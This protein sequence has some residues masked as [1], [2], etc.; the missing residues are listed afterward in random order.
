[1]R[2]FARLTAISMLAALVTTV[3]AQPAQAQSRSFTPTTSQRYIE[4]TTITSEKRDWRFELQVKNAS[5]IYDIHFYIDTG[6]DEGQHPGPEFSVRSHKSTISVRKYPSQDLSEA[7]GADCGGKTRG[8]L[9]GDDAPGLF[10][11]IPQKCLTYFL[12]DGSRV[13]RLRVNVVVDGAQPVGEGAE[14][15][16]SYSPNVSHFGPWVKNVT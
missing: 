12:G 1:M 16:T 9:T 5:E 3:G 8:S 7:H 15:V 4:R 11:T 6:N 2:T 10:V 13:D 14:T